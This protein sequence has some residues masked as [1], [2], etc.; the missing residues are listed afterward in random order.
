MRGRMMCGR[1]MR[2]RRCVDGDECKNSRSFIRANSTIA[3]L[4]DTTPT[5]MFVCRREREDFDYVVD[6]DTNIT[7]MNKEQERSLK[8]VDM[9]LKLDVVD[10]VSAPPPKPSVKKSQLLFPVSHT[11]DSELNIV[12]DELGEAAVVRARHNPPP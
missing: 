10:K 6:M 9:K 12:V 7:N 8:F 3:E 4:N 1:M 5:T 2:G 11:M